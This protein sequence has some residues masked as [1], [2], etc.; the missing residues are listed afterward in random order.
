[1][2]KL[3]ERR[4]L[5]PANMPISEGREITAHVGSQTIRVPT[6]LLIDHGRRVLEDVE[7]WKS[8]ADGRQLA[9]YAVV[10]AA[11]N[12][13]IP[14]LRDMLKN[15][16]PAGIPPL[17][18]RE[19]HTDPVLYLLGYCHAF[20]PHVLSKGEFTLDVDDAG[21][22]HGLDWSYLNEVRAAQEPLVIDAQAAAEEGD[23]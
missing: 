19:R 10:K 14:V 11:L 8:R 12:L 13:L 20:L 17:P 18:K 7:N 9:M 5:M 16:E 15:G 22:T 3:R 1:M 21:E 23:S 4:E 2:R 6:A